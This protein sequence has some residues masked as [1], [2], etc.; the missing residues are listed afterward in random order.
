V[1]AATDV[2]E[3]ARNAVKSKNAKLKCRKFST[4]QK[5][6]IKMRQKNKCFT[7]ISDFSL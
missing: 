3:N 5:R 2:R 7:V 4:L 1:E 6:E